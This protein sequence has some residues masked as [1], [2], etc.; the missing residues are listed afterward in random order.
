MAVVM[1]LMLNSVPYLLMAFVAAHRMTSVSQCRASAYRLQ[2]LSDVLQLSTKQKRL[3][4]ETEPE[5][6]P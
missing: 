4:Q 2:S 1:G 5:T 3:Q 6:E